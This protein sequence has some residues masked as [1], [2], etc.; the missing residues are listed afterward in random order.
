MQA[1][2]TEENVMGKKTVDGTK[3]LTKR[4]RKKQRSPR[5][6]CYLLPRQYVARG[7]IIIEEIKSDPDLKDRMEN[8][9]KPRKTLSCLS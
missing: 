5:G 4:E 9:A 7:D 8:S 1:P 3:S 6:N 2:G